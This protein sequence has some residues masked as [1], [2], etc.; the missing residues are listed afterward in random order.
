MFEDTLKTLTESECSTTT[1][2]KTMFT[3]DKDNIIYSVV[4]ELKSQKLRPHS[5][6]DFVKG[7]LLMPPTSS[8]G[9]SRNCAQ[10]SQRTIVWEIT[11]MTEDT[12]NTGRQA[13][14]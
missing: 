13:V 9:Q 7:P 2:H 3:T 11:E 6:Q 4:S 10:V 5:E 14:G 8:A 1:F 12:G